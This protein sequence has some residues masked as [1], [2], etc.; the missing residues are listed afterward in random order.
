MVRKKNLGAVVLALGVMIGVAAA[1]ETEKSTRDLDR[2][3]GHW[4][5]VDQSTELAGFDYREE[6]EVT[7][8]YVYDAAYI[9]CDG[10]GVSN[11]RRREFVEYLNYNS[12]T[13]QYE[14]VGMFQNHP[15]KARFTMTLADDGREIEQFGA[16]M[17]QRNGATTR[18]WG[19]IKFE[20][21]DKYVWSTRLHRSGQDPNH[22]PLS[23]IGT[24]ER[25][26]E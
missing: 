24:Y 13:D 19:K 18:N 12:I 25:V 7:C 1:Q 5:F 6:G 21:D 22:W 10:F 26:E 9:R 16:P 11:D 3:I 2:L 4:R 23:F 14:R 17:H 20:S 8:Q 15:A